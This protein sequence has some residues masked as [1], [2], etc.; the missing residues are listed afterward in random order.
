MPDYAQMY[1]KLFRA[2][3]KSIEILQ[4]AQVAAEE[5]FISAKEPVITILPKHEAN[6]N[7]DGGQS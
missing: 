3:T 6:E 2:I 7:E 1:H 5:V 4:Q